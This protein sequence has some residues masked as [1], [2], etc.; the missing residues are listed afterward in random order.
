MDEVD[1]P[2][3]SQEGPREATRR[4]L[5]EAAR[6]LFDRQG[7]EA[8]TIRQV[9]EAAGVTER[10]FYRYFDGKEGLVAQDS[11]AWIDILHQAILDRPYEEPPYVAVR[12]ALVVVA[13]RREHEVGDARLWPFADRAR[14]RPLLPRATTRPWLRLENSIADALLARGLGAPPDPI[15]HRPDPGFAAEVLARLASGALRSAVIRRRRLEDR[16]DREDR[17]AGGEGGEGV[18]PGV[19]ALLDEAFSVIADLSAAET[20]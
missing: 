7:V 12:R 18:A 14:A 8:T 20:P 6:R 4:L 2:G 10:T 11:L 16:G 5:L 13:A 1:R 15:G 9:A 17:E 3:E 19:A